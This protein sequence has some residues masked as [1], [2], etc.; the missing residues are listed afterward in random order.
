MWHYVI[1]LENLCMRAFS[2]E[3]LIATEME[4]QTIFMVDITDRTDRIT[5]RT[6]Q[7]TLENTDG[8][9]NRL[10]HLFD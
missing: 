10:R 4:S 1:K 6:H 8:E 9:W 3:G 2:V 5:D 7:V